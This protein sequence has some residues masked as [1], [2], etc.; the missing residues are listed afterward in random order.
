MFAKLLSL[1]A[2][3]KG[4][5]VAAA[6]V[7]AAATATVGATTP[8]VQDAVKQVVE[9]VTGQTSQAGQETIEE[10]A[11]LGIEMTAPLAVQK[12]S[13]DGP[14]AGKTLKDAVR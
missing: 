11:S 7:L 5:T 14:L 2:A 12:A 10:L 9:T 4:A 1:I 3:T 6:V 13:A 8:E